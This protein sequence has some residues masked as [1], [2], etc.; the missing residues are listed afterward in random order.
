[1]RKVMMVIKEAHNTEKKGRQ[2][3]QKKKSEEAT[4]RTQRTK[5]IIADIKRGTTRR[6]RLNEDRKGSSAKAAARR[7][8]MCLRMR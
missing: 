3:T 2:T 7:S 1:M 8:R 4:K 5:A 6:G